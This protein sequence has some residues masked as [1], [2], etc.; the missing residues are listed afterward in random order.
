MP[1]GPERMP[2]PMRVA[3][4]GRLGLTAAAVAGATVGHTVGY[5]IVARRVGAGGGVGDLRFLAG[6]MANGQLWND[7]VRQ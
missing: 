7:V 2:C 1:T 3:G 5:L 4:R 6:A